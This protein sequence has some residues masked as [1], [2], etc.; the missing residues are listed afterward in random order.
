MAERN[1]EFYQQRIAKLERLQARGVD[2]FPP[3][4]QRTHTA[5][6]AVRAFTERHGDTPS[7]HDET[8]TA[9]VG[10]I[11]AQ[12]AMGKASFLDLRDGS[13]RIQVY[14]RGDKVGDEAYKGLE[15]LDLGDFL[16]VSGPLF[17]TRTGEITVEAH[18][19]QMLAKALQPPPLGKSSGDQ[20]WSVL[21]DVEVRLRHRYLDLLANEEARHTFAARSRIVAGIRRYMDDRGFLEMKTPI[22]QAQAGGAM[23]KPF[24][25]HYNALDQ[26][27]F[28][29]IATELHLKRLLV[30]GFERVYE[31]G[32]IFRNEGLSHKHNPEYT[33]MESY[34][35]YAGYQDVLH[36]VEDLVSQVALQVTG[37][38]TVP[39]GEEVIDLTPPW[40][41]MTLRDAIQQQSGIDFLAYETGDDLRAAMAGKRIYAP[42]GAGYGKLIDELLSTC[43]EPK[44]IQ[45][46]FLTDYPVELSPLAKKRADDPRLVERFECFVIGIEIANAFTELNDPLEQRARFTRQAQLR[47]LGDEEAE[48]PDEDFL[49]ALEHGMPPA[50]GLGL[51]IDRLT[52]LLTNQRSIREVILFPQLRRRE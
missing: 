37:S 35:A 29:R 34:Q 15:D 24:T 27:F 39:W 48:V 21:T 26:E 14:L 30:G 6:Q 7:A 44:L 46:T 8:D 28:L 2:P 5:E 41:Q 23:A 20:A 9:V 10:R 16:Q 50:G 32:R 33:S 11:T 38:M 52:M 51:G 45:P 40:R 19:Y 4:T 36:M 13:G 47:A 12:R 3:S 1:E 18:S 43:V 42:P 25:T 22:L 49:F 31:I 17:R